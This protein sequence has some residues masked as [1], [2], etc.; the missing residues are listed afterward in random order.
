MTSPLPT[1]SKETFL[2]RDQALPPADQIRNTRDDVYECVTA[3]STLPARLDV[4]EH[5]LLN[6]EASLDTHQG[7]LGSLLGMTERILHHL[8][9]MPAPP[10]CTPG[11]MGANNYTN[12]KQQPSTPSAN[13]NGSN[14]T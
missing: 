3:L 4:F 8:E 5:R 9:S 1:N 2:A 13:Q 14:G 12:T 7:Q 11:T 6:I 10:V